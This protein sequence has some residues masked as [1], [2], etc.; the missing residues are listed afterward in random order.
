MRNLLRTLLGTNMSLNDDAI[1]GMKA[2][3]KSNTSKII[4]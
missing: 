3:E 4:S 1:G 2:S